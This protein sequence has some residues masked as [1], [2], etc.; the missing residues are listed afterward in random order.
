[1]LRCLERSPMS[2]KVD[3]HDC[4]A[5]WLFTLGGPGALLGAGI[6]AMTVTIGSTVTY[7]PNPVCIDVVMLQ[8]VHPGNKCL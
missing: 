6:R 8:P 5:Q 1:M 7:T 2:K 3:Q 4:S